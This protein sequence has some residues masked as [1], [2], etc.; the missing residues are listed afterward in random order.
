MYTTTQF[1]IGKEL[2]TKVTLPR[3]DIS[4]HPHLY[5]VCTVSI[6]SKVELTERLQQTSAMVFIFL[7]EQTGILLPGLLC[8]GFTIHNW[9][10]KIG[11]K[12]YRRVS[13]R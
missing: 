1:G 3:G 5:M 13:A 9:L 10:H 6:P 12:S 7:N 4:I 8:T 2:A 11:E